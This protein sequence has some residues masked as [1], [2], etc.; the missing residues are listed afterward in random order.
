MSWEVG[1][2]SS[3]SSSLL[4]HAFSFV[5]A[6]S[7]PATASNLLHVKSSKFEIRPSHD[8]HL[9][10]QLDAICICLFT[11]CPYP[12]STSPLV[13][14]T[15]SSLLLS[16]CYFVLLIHAP[17]P[18]ETPAYCS[19]RNS[20]LGEREPLQEVG[21]PVLCIPPIVRF[22]WIGGRKETTLQC[23]QAR[24]SSKD[25]VRNEWVEGSGRG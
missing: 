19:T 12:M 24:F 5:L 4:L 2:S 9:P 20:R 6:P 23:Q 10:P 15:Q 13:P 22:C 8:L 14:R 21:S 3:S 25:S 11:P 1:G 18:Y 7:P 17:S 16:R